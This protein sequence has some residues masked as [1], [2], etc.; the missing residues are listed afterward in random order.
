ML[1]EDFSYGAVAVA[2]RLQELAPAALVLVGAEQRGR[3]AGTVERRTGS[4]P[5]G[6]AQ[7]AVADAVTGYV[8]IDLVLDVAQ[9]LGALPREITVV[10]LEPVRVEPSDALSTEAERALEPA[11]ELVRAELA[12]P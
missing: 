1:L 11:L 4:S 12:G 7:S 2:Q 10:E 6:D 5:A 8:S 9:A 3:E